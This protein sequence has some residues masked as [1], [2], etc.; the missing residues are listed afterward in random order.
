MTRLAWIP[1][2]MLSAGIVSLLARMPGE[3]PGLGTAVAVAVA[4]AVAVG[5]WPPVVAVPVA[6]PVAVVSDALGVSVPAVVAAAVP[7]VSG[8]RGG[9]WPSPPSL[10]HATAR[11]AVRMKSGRSPARMDMEIAYDGRSEIG[12]K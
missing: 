12:L 5:V 1:E 8:T 2:S 9:V 7:G 11:N 4:E 3:D 10:E 6:V